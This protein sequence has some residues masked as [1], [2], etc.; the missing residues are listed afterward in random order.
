MKD[1]TTIAVKNTTYQRLIT[2]CRK[3]QTFDEIINILLDAFEKGTTMDD[4][5]R[6]S[7]M[8]AI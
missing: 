8:E 3:D 1:G 6:R 7:Q 5:S 2:H 4:L